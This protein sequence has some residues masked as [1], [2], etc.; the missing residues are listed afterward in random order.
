[1]ERDIA[2][3][4]RRCINGTGVVIHTNLGRAPL[5]EGALKKINA[6]ARGYCNLEYEVEER[7]RGGRMA[8]VK[9]LLCELTGAESAYV[10]NNN[11]R[12]SHV[13]VRNN[14]ERA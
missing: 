4:L 10:V 13:R 12:G 6:I 9:D 1:L 11:A 8:G 14:C 5:C 2:G 3:D 7:R